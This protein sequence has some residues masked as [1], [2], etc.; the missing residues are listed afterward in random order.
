MLTDAARFVG[1]AAA[2]SNFS[3]TRQ[4]AFAPRLGGQLFVSIKSAGFG[5][6]TAIPDIPTAPVPGL[7]TVTFCGAL[8]VPPAC[9]P[10]FKLVADRMI[11]GATA[12]PVNDTVC[13]LPAAL[14]LTIRPAF[15]PPLDSGA[16]SIVTVQ[17]APLATVPL[18]GQGLVPAG[19]IPKLPA[20]LPVREP[21]C[22]TP[23]TLP[24]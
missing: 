5:P 1:P 19:T 14:S 6:V 21:D 18:K 2:G 7:D 3:V 24:E 13:G 9:E 12:L 8:V 15:F 11:V 4:E 10:K 22:T 17:L 20:S 23:G 16:K